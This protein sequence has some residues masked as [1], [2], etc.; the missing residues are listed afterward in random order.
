MAGVVVELPRRGL[1]RC[2]GCRRLR[3]LTLC[4]RLALPGGGWAL[5]CS[6]CYR[7]EPAGRWRGLS[8]SWDG[9]CWQPAE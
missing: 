6:A 4:L 9:E 8:L 5:T 7:A 1:G 2:V 3:A